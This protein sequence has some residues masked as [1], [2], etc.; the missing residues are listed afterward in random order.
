MAEVAASPREQLQ[1]ELVGEA[2]KAGEVGEASTAV[3]G[4][5]ESGLRQVARSQ[6]SILRFLEKSLQKCI[7]LGDSRGDDGM[8]ENLMDDGNGSPVTA[9]A[10]ED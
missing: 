8:P 10:A 3:V 2:G 1:C 6:C 5:R 9:P 7:V 4:R